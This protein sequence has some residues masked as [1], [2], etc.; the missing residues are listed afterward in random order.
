VYNGTGSIIAVAGIM[1]SYS[2]GGQVMLTSKDTD[3]VYSLERTNE[4]GVRP[5]YLM[6]HTFERP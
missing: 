4:Y 6:N 2:L 5:G 1:R 3:Y